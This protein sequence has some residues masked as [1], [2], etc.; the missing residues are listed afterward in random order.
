MTE[1]GTVV[2]T[3]AGYVARRT[4]CSGS[5]SPRRMKSERGGRCARP[6]PRAGG[7]LLNTSMQIGGAVVLPSSPRSSKP[8]RGRT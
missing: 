3:A 7:A 4:V 1:H 8:G 6:G 2:R 5:A